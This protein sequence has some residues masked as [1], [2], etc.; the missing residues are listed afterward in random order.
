MKRFICVMATLFIFGIGTSLACEDCL[1]KGMKN[2]DTGVAT[3]WTTCWT[4][5]TGASEGCYVLAT[6][7]N[8]KMWSYADSCPKVAVVDPPSGTGGGTA[9]GGDGTNC[10]RYRS[11]SCPPDCTSCVPYV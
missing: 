9:S 7:A 3:E 10:P 1:L 11:G 8:C 2:P 5:D 6:G 4:H